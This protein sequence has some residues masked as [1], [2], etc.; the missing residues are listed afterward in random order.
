MLPL[1][2]V[3][4]LHNPLQLGPLGTAF[5]F[6]TVHRVVLR[7]PEATTCGRQLRK[8]LLAKR[9]AEAQ[10]AHERQFPKDRVVLVTDPRVSA[11]EEKLIE[12]PN[13]G[14]PADPVVEEVLDYGE[15][16]SKASSLAALR[17]VPGA[18]A[19]VARLSLSRAYFSNCYRRDRR[20]TA[21]I[22]LLWW[23][24]REVE[25]EP[26]VA[27]SDLR[28]EPATLSMEE[29]VDLAKWY[30]IALRLSLVADIG[31]AAG[32]RESVWRLAGLAEQAAG[33]TKA[34]SGASLLQWI[35]RR[36]PGMRAAFPRYRYE[37][38]RVALHRERT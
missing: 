10:R 7:A 18:R 2:C 20:W 11:S 32:R 36:R 38:L 28:E 1:S 24:L 9:A 15:L 19:E 8:D 23:T 16:D 12:K 17:R 29:F 27:A 3:N 21:G 37:E 25:D 30:V 4:C 6:C 26:V 34:G 22:H 14:L 33:A 5:G 35:R 13:G 31:E